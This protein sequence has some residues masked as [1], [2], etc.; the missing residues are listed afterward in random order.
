MITFLGVDPGL[1]KTGYGVIGIKGGKMLHLTH[2]TIS[3]DSSIAAGL[4][5][6]KIHTEIRRIIK[7]YKP[8]VG[9]IESLYFAKNITSAM[10]VA[11]ARGVVLLAF[12]Q[13]G[14]DAKEFPPQEIKQAITGNG[15]ATKAQVQELVRFLLALDEIPRPDHSADA[16]AAAICC[17][18]AVTAEENVTR[19]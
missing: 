19:A 13:E 11:Q 16:L 7:T 2:G 1:A 6:S 10:P 8:K 18:H 12:A 5:L 17:F 9:G 15:R 3:T 14:T 4:R